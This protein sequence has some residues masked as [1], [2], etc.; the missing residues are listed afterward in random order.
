MPYCLKTST[1]L[2][3]TCL[4][5]SSKPRLSHLSLSPT[6]NSCHITRES[7]LPE[8]LKVQHTK[9]IQWLNTPYRI[10]WDA[11]SPANALP[12]LVSTPTLCLRLNLHWRMFDWRAMDRA[13][14]QPLKT[15]TRTHTQRK[16]VKWCYKM[17]Y[18][19]FFFVFFSH[20]STITTITVLSSSSIYQSISITL[21]GTLC[22]NPCQ[23]CRFCRGKGALWVS[24]CS[25]HSIQHCR[26]T[27]GNA[28]LCC[29][30]LTSSCIIHTLLQLIMCIWCLFLS[31]S[32]SI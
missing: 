10:T 3:Q 29:A 15:H 31:F 26:G 30:N 6:N 5:V 17:W 24:E 2:N 19:A 14:H 8:P 11:S 23:K 4:T 12:R 22:L 32:L 1:Y 28:A 9:D 13:L 25:F 27:L 21:R 16:I 18:R 20:F 7:F